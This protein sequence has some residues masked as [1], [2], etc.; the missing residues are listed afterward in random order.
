MIRDRILALIENEGFDY[1]YDSLDGAGIP[2]HEWWE[3]VECHNMS[4]DIELIDHTKDCF[5][6]RVEEVIMD[7]Y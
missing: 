1:H 2:Q 6:G 4:T 7:S 3:C 5:V